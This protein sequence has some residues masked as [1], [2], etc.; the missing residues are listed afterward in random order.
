MTIIIS[1]LNS[2][3]SLSLRSRT[4]LTESCRLYQIEPPIYTYSPEELTKILEENKDGKI[5]L[6]SNFP[7]DSSF[8][9][10]KIAVESWEVDSY[11]QSMS[12]FKEWINK[13]S[14]K[15]IHIITGAPR[16][17]LGDREI[18]SLDHNIDL[19]IT[20]KKNWVHPTLD[21]DKLFLTFIIEKIREIVFKDP[22][23]G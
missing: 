6:F 21:Y 3:S 4:N 15:G 14:F 8:K 10:N 18:K 5:L 1:E 7:P 9:N 22:F 17:K 23:G 19:T 11:S 16:E 13:Y 12:L 20:R 2:S